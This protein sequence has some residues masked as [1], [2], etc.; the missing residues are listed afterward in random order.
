MKNFNKIILAFVAISIL[1]QCRP[2]DD[3]SIGAPFNKVQGLSGTWEI[4]SAVLI[5]EQSI[6]K[7]ETDLNQ[8]YTDSN[9]F[10]L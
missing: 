7:D 4:S 2:D 1:A 5:D 3:E 10:R 8:Y 6:L 9:L